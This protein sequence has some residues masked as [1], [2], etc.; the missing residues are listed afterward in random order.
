MKSFVDKE[1]KF[2]ECIGVL[3]LSL[4][5]TKNHKGSK[6]VKDYSITDNYIKDVF[7]VSVN[8]QNTLNTLEDI[9]IYIRNFP[10][11]RRFERQGITKSRYIKYHVEVYYLKINTVLDQLVLLLNEVYCLGIPEKKCN[12]DLISSIKSMKD[13]ETIKEIKRLNHAFSD[14]KELR[15]LSVHRGIFGDT[16]LSSIDSLEYIINNTP[17]KQRDRKLKDILNKKYKEALANK[18]VSIRILNRLISE[19]ILKFYDLVLIDFY[20]N[21]KSLQKGPKTIK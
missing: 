13:K 10:F 17:V 14:I 5:T 8:L 19:F 15:N 20:K 12:L 9:E 3:Y 1:I 11:D 21:Y 18:V 7:K 4:F 2:L 16:E 6:G